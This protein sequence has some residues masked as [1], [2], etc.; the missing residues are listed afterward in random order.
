M[1]TGLVQAVGKFVQV[2]PRPAGARLLIDPLDWSHTPAAGDSICVSGCCLT[3]ASP[4][5][6][7]PAGSRTPL[8]FDLV[9]ETLRLTTLGRLARGSPVN[10]EH[11][12]TP[13][14]LMGGHVVQ[15][16]VD[17]VGEVTHIRNDGEYRLRILPPGGAR[18]GLIQSIVPKGSIA[19][20]GVSLTIASVGEGTF[21]VAL[22]PTTLE[23]TTLG[24]LRAGDG[25]NLE[26]DLIAKTV[27]HWLRCFGRPG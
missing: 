2:E 13:T 12:V 15:G 10:L 26:T 18:G 22:I 24:R 11:A 14:T 4:P 1:F 5:S 8:A 17:G 3:V 6:S 23:R 19:V 27:V 20:D 7:S 9:H 16:H 21:E 25:V